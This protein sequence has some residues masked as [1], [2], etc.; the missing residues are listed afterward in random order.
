MKAK[1]KIRRFLLSAPAL[2]YS[3]AAVDSSEPGGKKEGAEDDDDVD[4]FSPEFVEVDRIISCDSAWTCHSSHGSLE[5]LQ[6]MIDDESIVAQDNIEYLVKWKGLPYSDCTWERFADIFYSS[7]AVFRF[8]KR[9]RH[10]DDS[11]VVRNS[12]PALQDYQKLEVGT[13]LFL[14]SGEPD[15]GLT[16]RDYQLEGVNWLLWNWWHKRSC[17]LADGIYL[18]S[19]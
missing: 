11:V 19:L 13:S 6:A 17:I 4:Y 15:G 5:D 9:Q 14:G 1:N 3:S 16:L 7:E 10:P 12:H 8:W 18:Q 2:G